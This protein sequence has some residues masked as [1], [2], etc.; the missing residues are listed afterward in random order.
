VANPNYQIERSPF[1][2]RR[3]LARLKRISSDHPLPLQQH[4]LYGAALCEI[5]A[6]V[7]HIG[8]TSQDGLLMQGLF[9]TR[10]FFGV[11]KVTSAFRGPLWA[12]HITD[13]EKLAAFK[14]LRTQ[15]SPW[16]WN[17]LT[18]MPESENNAQNRA[19]M[20]RA[21]FTR[22]LT[23]ASTIWLDVSQSSDTLLKDLDGKWRNQLKKAQTADLEV[24]IG[25]SKPKHYNWLLEH[26]RNQRNSR[27]Y[28]AVP[29]GLVPAYASAAQQMA[30]PA[31]IISINIVESGNR[32]A[33]A[34]FLLHGNSATYHIGWSNPRGRELNAL[35]LILFNALKALN[36]VGIRWLDLGGL[37][38]SAGSS[39]GIARF[40][41]GLGAPPY[42][43]V[44][45]YLG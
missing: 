13:E 45:T 7:Q 36:K 6:D 44:G 16:R 1:E 12:S 43:L 41:L 26:E 35:N 23:G 32:I 20:R 42:T 10:N 37:E 9:L 29:L 24:S 11:A 5:G 3:A 22:L 27:G 31:P 18:L 2:L 33:G 39:A 40:K 17:F 21:G 38:T 19:F 15:F 14:F 4:A 8:I 30:I 34:L 28:S 25:G